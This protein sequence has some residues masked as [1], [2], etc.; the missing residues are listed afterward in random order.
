MEAL[1]LTTS[2]YSNGHFIGARTAFG[3][4]VLP[5]LEVCYGLGS[6]LYD[7]AG[8]RYLDFACGSGALIFGHAD[9]S[10]A[11]TVYRQLSCVSLY[12]GQSFHNSVLDGYLSDLVRIAGGRF[13]RALTASSGTDA[14]EAACKLALQH[15]Q[16]LGQVNRTQIIGRSASYHGNSLFTLSVGGNLRRRAPYERALNRKPHAAAA[17]C[18]RCQFDQD[19]HSC[20][21]QCAKSIE[22]IFCEVGPHNVA[23]L[24]LEP[25]VGASLGAAVPDKRYLRQAREICDR[26][27]AL[28]IFDEVM[29]GFGRTGRP[30]AWQLWAVQPDIMV[31]GKAIS[32]GYFPLSAVVATEDV[33]HPLRES[34]RYFEN[35]HTFLYSPVAAAIGSYVI[36]R[37]ETD[38]LSQRADRMGRILIDRLSSLAHFEVIGDIRGVG[39]MAGIELVANKRFKR[40]FDPRESMSARF[41][42]AALRAGLV[43]YPGTGGPE[44]QRGDHIL[45]L[46]PLTVTESEIEIAGDCLFKAAKEMALLRH[47]S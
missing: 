7:S 37:I 26:Y 1:G 3:N 9:A 30:F 34:G 4:W 32:A 36:R 10:A 2:N 24:I 46:P 43:V 17:F 12:S 35:G 6:W 15:F 22:Q 31:L 47:P 18:Y 19:P 5:E 38:S 8:R 40:T 25:V 13:T 14:V 29:T 41:T 16:A 44:T 42:A 11:D 28:L 23:A 20:D 27:G 39:L 45:L 33:I 21:L